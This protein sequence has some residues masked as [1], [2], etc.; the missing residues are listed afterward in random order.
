M[1]GDDDGKSELTDMQSCFDQFQSKNTSFIQVRPSPGGSFV[2]RP[3]APSGSQKL[4]VS[5]PP[6]NLSKLKRDDS[7]GAGDIEKVHISVGLSQ[8]KVHQ[9]GQ[10]PEGGALE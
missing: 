8:I 2:G 7:Y 10:N 4:K 3:D 6:L 1:G 9:V 5:L